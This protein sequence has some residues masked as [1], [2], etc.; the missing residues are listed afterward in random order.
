MKHTLRKETNCLNCGG[1]VTGR[2]CPDCGQEN[3][4]PRE[5]FGYLV[6]HFFSDFTHFDTKF[7]SSFKYLC[8][9]PGF[10]TREYLA[11]KR[12]K[13]LPP[14]RMYIFISFVFF[15]VMSLLPKKSDE[16]II[17]VKYNNA[18]D[19][20]GR[21][22]DAALP[23]QSGEDSILLKEMVDF[24]KADFKTVKEF[25]SAYAKLHAGKKV[26][27]IGK[28]VKRTIVKWKEKYGDNW[29]EAFEEKL[30][31][32]VPKLMFILLPF[33][34]LILKLFYRKP[35]QYIDHA[36]FSLH[37]HSFAFLFLLLI[38]LL[39][40]L[41]PLSFFGLL[42]IPVIVIYLVAALKRMYGRSLIRS[43]L[44][45]LL[46]LSLYGAVIGLVALFAIVYTAFV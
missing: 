40:R 5:S 18:A 27:K 36:I 16:G 44:R 17:H 4:P 22:T 38:N 10:L 19:S 42:V 26:S 41:L 11:G 12:L 34:A 31:H 2:F 30:K 45:G 23:K 20:S 3:T 39:D 32:M 29:G 33:F 8:F 9:K 46:I 21:V 13:Y 37:F 24:M 6:Y 1:E 7:F 35:Y 15:L 14:V 43:S 28:T 25:D